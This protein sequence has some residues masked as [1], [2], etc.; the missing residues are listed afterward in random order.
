MKILCIAGFAAAAGAMGISAVLCLA[1]LAFCAVM[2][3]T[4]CLI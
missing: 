2:I 3:V 4:A 1:P